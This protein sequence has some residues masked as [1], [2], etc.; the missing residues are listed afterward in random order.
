MQT[1]HFVEDELVLLSMSCTAPAPSLTPLPASC[2]TE[3]QNTAPALP[4]RLN[5]AAGR[6]LEYQQ[7]NI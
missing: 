3:I 1:R 5:K 7:G 6:A 4:Q 2:G